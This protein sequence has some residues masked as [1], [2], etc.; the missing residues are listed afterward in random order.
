MTG[1]PAFPVYFVRHGETDWNRDSRFQGQRD[2]PL[3]ARGKA[4][5]AENGHILSAIIADLH[6]FRFVSS[7]LGRT[8]ETMEILRE[9]MGLARHGYDI[10][11]RLIEVSFGVWEG[12]TYPELDVERPGET[13]ARE[14][15]KWRFV[16]QGGESYEQL[17]RRFRPFLEDLAGPAIVVTHGGVLRCVQHF[18]EAIS[19]DAAAGLP[20]PQDKVYAVAGNTAGWL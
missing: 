2:I 8:R 14:A 11:G 4:Q 5:A 9:T 19:G 10:D 17:S 13:A 18:L 1:M 15:D 12:R 3:N 16:P 7:P 20:V 6:D